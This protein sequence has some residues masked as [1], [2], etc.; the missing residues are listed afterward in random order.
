MNEDNIKV[1]LILGSVLAAV[2]AV[3]DIINIARTHNPD[4]Q[5]FIGPIIVIVITVLIFIML[6]IL[7][8]RKAQIPFKGVVMVIFVVLE[9][10]LSGATLFSL[11][12]I[13]IIIEIVATTMLAMGE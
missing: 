11:M 8:V 7:H 2:G 3:I 6:G 1:L 5:S 12:G 10:F 9:I 13:G 4:V